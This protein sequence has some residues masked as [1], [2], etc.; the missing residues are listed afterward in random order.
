ML[1]LPQPLF[2]IAFPTIV[3]LGQNGVG[4]GFIGANAILPKGHCASKTMNLQ[5]LEF[6][7]QHG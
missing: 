2:L 5:T 1:G 6:V 3:S 4:T 7:D